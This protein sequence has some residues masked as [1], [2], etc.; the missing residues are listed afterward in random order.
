MNSTWVQMNPDILMSAWHMPQEYAE[1]RLR[2]FYQEKDA[3]IDTFRLFCID[4]TKIQKDMLKLRFWTLEDD[5][6]SSEFDIREEEFSG[7]IFFEKPELINFIKTLEMYQQLFPARANETSTRRIF[8]LIN[9]EDYDRYNIPK[10]SY[11]VSHGVPIYEVIEQDTIQNGKDTIKL[12][13][14]Y[15]GRRIS[16]RVVHLPRSIKAYEFDRYW[17]ITSGGLDISI[18]GLAELLAILKSK[19]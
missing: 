15:S 2:H 5:L 16:L 13:S 9:P 18:Q 4:L 14:I 8:E 1:N 11:L 7:I 12:F 3:V 17:Q 6:M 19:T 10:D